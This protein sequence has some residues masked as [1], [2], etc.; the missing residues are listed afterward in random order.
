MLAA[1][2]VV[3]GSVR[4]SD[5]YSERPRIVRRATVDRSASM[6]A[7]QKNAKA[8][9]RLLRRRKWLPLAQLCRLRHRLGRQFSVDNR[10]QKTSWHYGTI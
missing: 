8:T 6:A 4:A 9:F 1:W 3:A 10:P 5:D 7:R 2:S